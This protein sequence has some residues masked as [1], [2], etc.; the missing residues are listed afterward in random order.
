MNFFCR[1]ALICLII[2]INTGCYVTRLALKQNNLLNSKIHVDLVKHQ[3]TSTDWLKRK[4]QLV[5]EIISFAATEGLNTRGAYR[6][7]VPMSQSAVSYT[8][9]AADP[10]EFKHKTWWFPIVGAVPYLGFFEVEERDAKAHKLSSQGYDVYKGSVGAFSSLGWFD[11]PLYTPMLRRSHGYLAELL[12]HELI[13]RTLWVRNSVKFNENMA[14]FC[15]DVLTEKYL[16]SKGLENEWHKMQSTAD[17]RKK[18]KLWL[19]QLKETLEEL[20]QNKILTNDTK[21]K[22]KDEIFREFVQEKKPKFNIF[23]YIEGVVWNNATILAHSLY[24]PDLKSFQE[25]FK[26]FKND[27]MIDYLDSM[28]R[29]LKSHKDPTKA[30]SE[31]CQ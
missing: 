26:C 6:Y 9:E 15:A 25:S 8:L 3:A 23:D 18:F 11:D 29:I 31:L 30:L 27:R 28:E 14:T 7:Y 5:D 12:F 16:R 24:S 10:L 1:F 4:L 21:L 19:R 20:Y 22:R 13:H 17:D 2:T